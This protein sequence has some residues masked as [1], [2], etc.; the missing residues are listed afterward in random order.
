MKVVRL[1]QT[2]YTVKMD[3][4]RMRA[5]RK[6]AEPYRKTRWP[7]L[8]IAVSGLFL[9]IPFWTPTDVAEATK[10]IYV[11]RTY[12]MFMQQRLRKSVLIM[13]A[14]QTPVSSLHR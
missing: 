14:L 10:K 12:P 13:P 11:S 3:V 4:E 7:S 6:K 2:T 8:E 5:L 9:A 1:V